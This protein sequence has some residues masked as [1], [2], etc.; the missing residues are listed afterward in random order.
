M[1]YKMKLVI[2]ESPAKCK[3][4]EQ[5]LGNDYKCVASFG[6]IRG[7]L[8]GLKDI[9][10]E[11]GFKPTF[12]NLKEKGKYITQLKKSI[13]K[14]SEV[15]LATDDDRE[16]EAIAWH[17][18]K[19][20]KL[21]VNKTKRIIFNEITKPA[22]QLAIKNPVLVNMD[23]VNA[24]QA[25]QVLDLIVG[26]TIS[27]ILW[28]HVSRKMQLSAGRCQT[29]ALRLIYDND[30]LIKE[31]PGSMVYNTE[32]FHKSLPFKLNYH[33]TEPKSV[34]TFLELSKTHNHVLTSGDVKENI[35]KKPPCP[36]TTSILQQKASNLL[37]YSPKRTM[38][39]AQKLYEGG[40]ITY[41]RTDSYKYST[42]FLKE[43]KGFISKKYGESYVGNLGK[44]SN[45]QKKKKKDNSQEAHEAIRPTHIEMESV[46]N[47][48]QSL[49]NLIRINTLESCSIPAV[50][51]SIIGTINTPTKYVYKRSEEQI[52]EPGWKIINGYVEKNENFAYFEKLKKKKK[53]TYDKIESMPQLKNKKL[54][55]TEAKLVQT[56]EKKGI[57][58][59]S[60]F[61]NIISK[62]Q[63]RGYVKKMDV[64]G[65]KLN[66][67]TFKLMGNLIIKKD[68][69]KDFGAEK[70]KLVLQSTGKIVIEFLIKHF[71]SMFVYDYT[72]NMEDN[73][74]EISKGKKTFL[75]LCSICYNELIK[76]SGSIKMSDKQV[77]K[78]DEHH[79]YMI[80]KY[81]PVIRK[82]VDGETSFINVKKDLDIDKLK[83]NKYSLED[84]I[85]KKNSNIILGKYKNND[86][87]LKKGKFG[88]Y[89][90]CN[91]NNYSI[92]HVKK[93]MDK[94]KLSDVLEVFNKKNSNMLMELTKD[95]SI[96]KGKYGA[97]IFYKTEK[98]NKPRFLKLKDL[99]WNKMEKNEILDWI[100]NI[101]NI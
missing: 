6:H 5:F 16:G 58:R 15:I 52:V 62:I 29:P 89:V 40:H 69:L 38:Q 60:T 10:I 93:K 19:V 82:D 39:V 34:N 14:A 17:I 11:H 27:P 20:F 81:G 59:P 54:H 64:E 25:R 41:M 72:K 18:C 50:Y 99:N 42:K 76:L 90:T 21:P 48:Y 55:F 80:G 61:S 26:Y 3:K 88:L 68:E 22:L 77:Y 31:N 74:D 91:G 94:I 53:I 23:K 84:I 45:K 86:V 46:D 49:Y 43:V 92:K 8:N 66:C 33:Y 30:N 70:N 71:D 65:T 56:L 36:L 87:I 83:N 96:R 35:V 67:V 85:E 98:M 24:Q 44:L 32:L 12:H 47:E 51:K 7:L 63:N 1:N 9:D 95:L 28:K 78:I 4:I 79:C 37:G 57:G 13:Q 75:D 2:V 100:S 101:Y 73:L 97:Y